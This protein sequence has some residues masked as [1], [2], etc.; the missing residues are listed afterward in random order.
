LKKLIFI[1]LSLTVLFSG[2]AKTKAATVTAALP[3]ATVSATS[4]PI[5]TA[6]PTP[7]TAKF[8]NP[9]TGI[10]TKT[11]IS[12]LRP[13]AVMLNNIEDA[14]PQWGQSQADI[15][16]EVLAEGGITRM[17]AVYQDIGAV[18]GEIGSVRSTRPYFLDIVQ[19]LDAVMLHCG[20]ST[21]AYEQ[22]PIRG[23]DDIDGIYNYTV[24]YRSAARIAAGYSTEHTLFTSG[25]NLRKFLLSDTSIR[26]NHETGYSYKMSFGSSSAVGGNS[27]NLLTVDFSDYK[28]TVFA[29]NQADG[30]YY[31]S[32]FGDDY[33]DGNS[34]KQV[35]MKN[36]LVLET[37]CTASGD[38]YGH[39]AVNLVGS[40]SGY[41]LCDGKYIEITWSKDSY[42]SQFIYKLKNG[43]DLVF[44][45]G[46]TYINIVNDDCDVTF[47]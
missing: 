16:Y 46:T 19:G 38:S 43:Q 45:P 18:V 33:Q 10:E 13:Y 21:E 24:F 27:A 9:F 7:S 36:V 40:G 35:S 32:Q 25:D 42:S 14:L 6:S 15:I 3:T 17:V 29:Y 1:L 11:D 34:G 8:T 31:V 37:A 4:K 5:V 28:D 44:S 41:Y 22:I 2:C 39:I 26:R 23:V 30:R 20:G 47:K 12:M